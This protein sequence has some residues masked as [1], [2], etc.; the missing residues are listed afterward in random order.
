[1][2]GTYAMATL[3]NLAFFT[4]YQPGS[5]NAEAFDNDVVVPLLGSKESEHKLTSREV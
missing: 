1:M 3:A 4:D 5:G 2:E